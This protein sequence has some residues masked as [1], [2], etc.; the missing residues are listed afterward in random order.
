MTK[1]NEIEYSG[2]YTSYTR[3]QIIKEVRAAMSEKRFNHVLR[4]EETAIQLAKKYEADV[5]KTSIA[6]LLHDYAKE[7]PASEMRDLIISENL[8]LDLLQY[9]PAIWHGPVGAVLARREFEVE[10]E[11][12]LRAIHF[13]TIGAPEMSVIEQIIYVAD[14]IE[15]G[16]DFDGVEKARELADFSLEEAVRFENIETIRRLVEREVQ[17][18]PK[19]IDAY[20]AWIVYEDGG[21]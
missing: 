7:Q 3:D 21:R 2:T 5:E 10:D 14:Y 17:I 8:D 16:R 18:Y 6:A 9:G 12:V 20:N 19:A 4:V 11:E 13:H 15:P 1:N